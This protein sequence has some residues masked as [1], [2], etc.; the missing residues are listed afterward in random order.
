MSGRNLILAAAGVCAFLWYR[1]KTA[2]GQLKIAMKGWRVQGMTADCVVLRTSFAI[3]NPTRYNFTIGQLE[4]DLYL[5]GEK[6]GRA[7]CPINRRIAARRTMTINVGLQISTT[8]TLK[9]VWNYFADPLTGAYGAMI[10]A[11]DGTITIDEKQV[12]IY[13]EYGLTELFGKN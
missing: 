13:N 5:N 8:E 3:T 2:Y 6:V 7:A 11:I 1:A 12:R 9:T 4:A 10:L